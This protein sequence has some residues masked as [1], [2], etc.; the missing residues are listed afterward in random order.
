MR[1][2]AMIAL[3]GLTLALAACGTTSQ[4]GMALGEASTGSPQPVEGFDW[5]LHQDG[6]MAK[7]AYGVD[8]TDNTPIQLLC[9]R[10]S[11]Q[12]TLNAEVANDAAHEFHLESGGETERYP[13]RA[14]R[15][16][17]EE[18]FGNVL[19]LNAEAK[20]SDPVFLRFRRVAWLAVWQ[21]GERHAFASHPGSEQRV[22]RFFAFCG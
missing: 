17:P 21:H 14:E 19:F 7:L 11:G 6:D 5:V 18:I 20:T 22:E 16:E 4:P 12:L 15:G 10:T 3:S 13:A 9:E 1:A 2:P 8:E